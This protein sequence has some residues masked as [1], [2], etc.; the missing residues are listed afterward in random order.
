MQIAKERQETFKDFDK[1]DY[2]NGKYFEFYTSQS[3]EPKYEKV[4]KLFDGLEIPTSEDWKALQKE[5]ETHGLFHAYRLAIAPT[6][7]ISY[8]QNV[9]SS[10]MPI[11]DIIDRRTYVFI[12]S[13]I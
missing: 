2:A 13:Y 1:S 8:V 4:R 10:V 11:V 3:F 12:E 5:V 9:T 6:Q 7:S